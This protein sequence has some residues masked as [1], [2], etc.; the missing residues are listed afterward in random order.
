MSGPI[1]GM[2]ET[3][4]YRWQSGTQLGR[5]TAHASFLEL[6]AHLFPDVPGATETD[7]QQSRFQM[8]RAIKEL[9]DA[10]ILSE[11][12]IQELLQTLGFSYAHLSR[13]F[14]GAFGITPVEYRNAS[15]LEQAKILLRDTN[16]PLAEVGYRAGFQDAGYFSRQFRKQNQVGPGQ[17]R[18]QI[19]A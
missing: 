1:P 3:V 15:R 8:A 2:V 7:T 16:L 4:C 19:K 18:I 9:L 6:I 14:R 12:G 17:F 13:V 11:L 10:N 5:T